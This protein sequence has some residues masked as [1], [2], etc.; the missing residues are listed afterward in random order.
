MRHVGV[1]VSDLEQSLEFYR[2]LLGLT[3]VRRLEERGKHMDELLA[4]NDV[5]VTT[6]KLRAPTGETLVELLKFDSHPAEPGTQPQIHSIGPTHL[7]FTV[8]DIDAMHRRLSNAGVSFLSG[9]Q[10]SPDGYARVAFCLD[11]DGTPLELVEV[12]DPAAVGD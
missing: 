2:D 10:A 6:V 11:P 1:V 4:L 8:V 5:R 12:L 7:A 3:V 9:P